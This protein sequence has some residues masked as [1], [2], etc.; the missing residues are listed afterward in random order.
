MGIKRKRG[1]PRGRPKPMTKKR[2]LRLKRLPNGRLQ[3]QY[4][5]IFEEYINSNNRWD[6]RVIEQV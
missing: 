6:I 1:R 5:R 2:G 3:D 4:G